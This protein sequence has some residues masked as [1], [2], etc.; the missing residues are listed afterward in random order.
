MKSDF[1]RF[2][3]RVWYMTLRKNTSDSIPFKKETIKGREML[4]EKEIQNQLIIVMSNVSMFF[5][6]AD[7][8]EAFKHT[9][10]STLK[11]QF[12]YIRKP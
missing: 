2:G 6:N 9:S 11:S 8:P 3:P 12:E 10:L 4:T 7:L 5:Q 1:E